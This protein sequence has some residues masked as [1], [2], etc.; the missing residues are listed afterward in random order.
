[1]QQKLWIVYWNFPSLKKLLKR[2]KQSLLQGDPSLKHM[3][4]F[5]QNKMG[6]DRLS[7]LG[8][9][10]IESQVLT[11][12]IET[13]SFQDSVITKFASTE[14]QMESTFK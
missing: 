12:V 14:R 5:S 8:L 1:M 7:N 6:Q 11:E 2:N 10:S 3:K 4:S 13:K 9:I